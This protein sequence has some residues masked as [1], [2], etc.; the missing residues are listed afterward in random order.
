MAEKATPGERLLHEMGN[1]LSII[2]G[3][4]DL[5][6]DSI[7]QGDPKHDDI[8]EV[9]NAAHAALQLFPELSKHLK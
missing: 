5:L 3:F 4:A 2:V 6:I 1:H 7:P 9:R 8:L